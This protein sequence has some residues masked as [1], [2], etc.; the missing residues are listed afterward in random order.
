MFS[1]DDLKVIVGLVNFFFLNSISF[2]VLRNFQ[3]GLLRFY[4]NL[5][6]LF[7]LCVDLPFGVDTEND[8]PND[9]E[10]CRYWVDY[11]VQSADCLTSGYC[12]FNAFYCRSDVG[13]Q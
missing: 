11:D 10:S 13:I 6:V 3:W 7:Y 4:L 1:T 5:V 12:I 2:K 8:Q 9:T